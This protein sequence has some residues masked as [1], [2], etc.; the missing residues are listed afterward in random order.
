[1]AFFGHHFVVFVEY[2]VDKGI[3]LVDI[4]GTVLGVSWPLKLSQNEADIFC[5]KHSIWN[6]LIQF[7]GVDGARV[8][9]VHFLDPLSHLS[10]LWFLAE[11][12]R[13]ANQVEQVAAVDALKFVVEE[14]IVSSSKIVKDWVLVEVNGT[15][16]E[17]M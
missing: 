12:A 16:Q 9:V 10:Y 17:I 14:F 4:E 13:L 1:M 8:V 15:V 11:L 3:A 6:S 7:Q 2:V 5:S